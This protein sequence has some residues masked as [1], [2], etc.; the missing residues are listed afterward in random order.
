MK[1]KL[2]LV[3][4]LVIGLFIN[5]Y[6]FG[7]EFEIKFV[8][9]T[10]NLKFNISITTT[11]YAWSQDSSG[12]IVF[13]PNYNFTTLNGLSTI[14]FDAPNDNNGNGGGVMPWGLMNIII[15]V[16]D[17]SG[18]KLSSSGIVI[19]FR[20]ARWSTGYGSSIDTHI[21]IDSTT[22]VMYLSQDGAIDINGSDIILGGQLINMWDFW[23][24]GTPNTSLFKV[25]V[26]L[27]NKI[28]GNANTS[29]G[30]LNSNGHTVTSSDYDL[31]FYNINQSVS[32]GTL[33]T[34][35]NNQRYYSFN[36]SPNQNVNAGGGS[37]YSSSF[38][39]SVS[40]EKLT[41]SITRYFRAVYPL[42]IKNNLGE[43][44]GIS[45]DNIYFKDPIT[46]NTYH[47][48]PASGSGYVKDNAFNDLHIDLTPLTEQKYG[49]KAVSTI[50]YNGNTY[51][52]SGGD[53]STTG[54]DF[55]ITAPATKVANYKGVRLS[56]D[57]SA[58]ASNGQRK[59]IKTPNGYLHQVYASLGKV[60]YERSTDNGVTWDYNERG[61]SGI[62]KHG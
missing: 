38:N 16:T 33:D 27:F 7:G 10:P 49:A 34:I 39:F 21:L 17:N 58:L 4:L 9:Y 32:E 29:F 60:W 61:Q 11:E 42:T 31:F 51:Q 55:I 41:K 24:Q 5:T 14:A 23:N 3:L 45:L 26:T 48:Y 57:T 6:P 56:S 46:D 37:I 18:Y 25:P 1:R 12:K 43:A 62:G 2:K 15:V 30:Y 59:L 22:Y 19:D 35:Y 36:W 47:T 28:E 53:F 13:I 44:G 50:S 54:T 20:D 8:P 40:R 52:Y